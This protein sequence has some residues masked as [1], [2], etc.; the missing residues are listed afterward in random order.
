[1]LPGAPRSA[2]HAHLHAVRNERKFIVNYQ[3]QSDSLMCTPGFERQV[4]GLELDDETG[5]RL[6]SLELNEKGSVPALRDHR[7]FQAL[8]QLKS[9]WTK[10]IKCP[11]IRVAVSCQN[12]DPFKVLPWLLSQGASVDRHSHPEWKWT[13]LKLRDEFAMWSPDLPGAYKHAYTLAF[14]SAYRLQAT[15]IIRQ[16]SNQAFCMRE[17][18]TEFEDELQRLSAALP[19]RWEAP[20]DIPF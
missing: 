12:A 4:I 11:E 2:R 5:V 19:E 14:L 6:V 9:Y 10:Y 13:R 7:K 16:L 3:Y 20:A 18:L 8:D 15:T 17:I 1:M